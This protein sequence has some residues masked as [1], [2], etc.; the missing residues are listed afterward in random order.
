M[1]R[2]PVQRESGV[3]ILVLHRDS[4][5]GEP[6]GLRQV[7]RA[8]EAVANRARIPWERN[9]ATVTADIGALGPQEVRILPLL[10]CNL[11]D[12]VQAELLSLIEIR[13]S[14]QPQQETATPPARAD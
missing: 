13:R 7:R 14:R 10:R 11:L 3:R 5:C 1:Q 8:S 6:R 9:A 12:L 4:G 2:T